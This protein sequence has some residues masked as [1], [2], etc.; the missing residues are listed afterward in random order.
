MASHTK[1]VGDSFQN[2]RRSPLLFLYGSPTLR[3]KSSTYRMVILCSQAQHPSLSLTPKSA[4]TQNTRKIRNLI[5]W[6]L[7][8]MN[9]K[10]FYS[11]RERVGNNNYSN[12]DFIAFKIKL[13]IIKGFKKKAL[14][15]KK[16]LNCSLYRTV[17][18]LEKFIWQ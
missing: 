2:F 3:D 10:I 15:K 17:H 6:K 11:G 7:L 16:H 14:K 8:I 4:K 18:L 13:N 12:K 5:L 9:S 1:P